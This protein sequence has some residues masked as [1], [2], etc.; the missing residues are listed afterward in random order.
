[1]NINEFFK[2]KSIL[3]TGASGFIGYNLYMLLKNAD[4]NVSGTYCSTKMSDLIRCDYTNINETRAAVNG[5]DYVFILA[6]KTYGANVMKESPTALVTDSIVMN[7]NILQ[8]CYEHKVKK[9]FYLSSGTVYQE[10]YKSLTEEELD[11]NK[12]PYKLY[13]GVGWVKRYTEQLCK[14]YSQLGLQINIVRPTD[15]YG[16]YERFEEG[17]SHFIPA[18]MRRIIEGQNPL[19]VWGNG[20]SVKDLIYIDDFLRDC[21]KVFMYHN[22]LDPI[23]I[24]S[25]TE[26]TIKDIVNMILQVSG[27][28]YDTEIKY[29]TTKPSSIPY[30]RISR[31]KFDSLYGRESYISLEEGLKKTYRWMKSQIGEKNVK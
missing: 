16:P 11:L 5:H 24:C 17:K 12:D 15:I 1:M 25:M 13:M 22:S 4:L 31:N 28:T 10:S 6:A 21:L 9:V 26:Y 30:R 18:V 23:N 27:K 14:F 29:D 2:N 20:H 3:I 8:A 19:V 7:S